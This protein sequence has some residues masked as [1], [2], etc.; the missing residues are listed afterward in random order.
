MNRI[1]VK[2]GAEFV[3]LYSGLFWSY[4]G[5]IM[6]LELGRFGNGAMEVATQLQKNR[7]IAKYYALKQFGEDRK[8]S[9]K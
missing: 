9:A 2:T 1:D 5:T 4:C 7:M 3:P 6:D 8:T